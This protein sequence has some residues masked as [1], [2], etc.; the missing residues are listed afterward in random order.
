M[1]ITPH[2]GTIKF[3][4]EVE[5]WRRPRN[6]NKAQGEAEHLIEF[7]DKNGVR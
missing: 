3:Q 1:L 4:K 6:F 2:S 5:D 7:A